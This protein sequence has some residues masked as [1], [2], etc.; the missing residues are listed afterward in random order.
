M[1]LTN[2]LWLFYS[3]ESWKFT[4]SIFWQKFHESNIFTKVDLTNFLP[5]RVRENFRN[6]HRVLNGHCSL[7]RGKIT[8]IYIHISCKNFVK[9]TSVLKEGCDNSFFS[10]TV[11]V[12]AWWTPSPSAMTSWT[13]LPSATIL[14]PP[15]LLFLFQD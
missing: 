1:F 2:T 8:E 11:T 14:R 9:R 6:F 10:E 7:H 4:L 15:R 3:V 12:M 5:K 13:L